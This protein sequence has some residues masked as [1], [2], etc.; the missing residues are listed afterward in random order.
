MEI[1]D[2]ELILFS[3]GKLIQPIKKKMN[4]V[5]IDTRHMEEGDIFVAIKGVNNDGHKFV[6]DACKKGASCLIVEKDIHISNPEVGVIKV[7][8]T[9]NALADI[10]RSKRQ[11]IGAKTIAITG[12]TGKTTTKEILARILGDLFS[13]AIS[14]GNFN[15]ELG[16][17]LTI[18]NEVTSSSQM[19]IL[20]MAMRGKGQIRQLC[21][22]SRP[23]Y[24]VI[25]NIGKSHLGELGS[26]KDIAMAK[27]EL[28]GHLGSN[29]V[30]VVNADSTWTELIT[31]MTRANIVT[32]GVSEKADV[33]IFEIEQT[34]A[35][36]KFKIKYRNQI[37]SIKT[38]VAGF[39]MIENI[40]AA[41]ATAISLSVKIEDIAQA[42]S[43]LSGYLSRQTVF[44][45]GSLT[46]I[47]DTY[48]ASPE[49]TRKGLEVLSLYKN[50][51][52]V[53]VL[54]NMAEL[55]K[56][57]ENLHFELGEYVVKSGVDLL[58]T[59]GKLSSNIYRGARSFGCLRE[60]AHFET[61]EAAVSGVAGMLEEND[62]VLVKGSRYMAMENI[63]D[64]IRSSVRA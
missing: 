21:D 33:Q 6:E 46:V 19:L 62:V 60:H 27:G 51:R 58:I 20:E 53:A 8:N 9:V 37:L 56:Q 55:G 63:V 47:D 59:V 23:D 35:S 5:S 11:S 7:K 22:I 28:A 2:K 30:L 57:A 25:T 18:I 16:L 52:R 61:T 26:E 49:S 64:K 15:N 54:G 43:N 4:K 17:S 1:S 31:R 34:P 42:V 12:S 3:G 36:S 44:N 32:F 50:R 14:K 48:N 40:A 39:H 38:D 29:S 41:M 13:V 24:G 45:S 10:A